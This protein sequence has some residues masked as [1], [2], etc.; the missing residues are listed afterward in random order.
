MST[1]KTKFITGRAG[2][3]KS[4]RLKKE[5]NSLDTESYVVLTPTHKSAKVL[6]D[7]GIDKEHIRTIHSYLGLIPT[8]NQEFR[9]DENI[10]KLE[11]RKNKN[12]ILYKY[13]FIDEFSMLSNEILQFFLHKIRT[14]LQSINMNVNVTIFG[15]SYQLPPVDG[16]KIIPINI[17][18]DVETL[19]IQYRADSKTIV[20]NF[21][22]FVKYLETN[23]ESLNLEIEYDEKFITKGDIK[24]FNPRTDKIVAFTNKKVKK[25]NDEVAGHLNLSKT[26]KKKDELVLNSLDVVFIKNGHDKDLITMFPTMI[27]KGVPAL[28]KEVS[29][30]FILDI[31]TYNIDLS[32]YKKCVV[33]YEGIYMN[34]FYNTNWYEDANMM[35]DEVENIQLSLIEHH[36]I[37]E[38]VVLK[39]WCKSNPKAKYVKERGKAWQRYLSHQNYVFNLQRP[40]ASTVHKSQ[41]SEYSTMFISIEDI[42]KAKFVSGK[43]MWAR[44]MYVSLSRAIKKIVII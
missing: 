5:V 29:N 23:D 21:E 26:Y 38:D 7:K 43:E 6:N 35:K 17:T 33:S 9:K 28:D 3:G 44:L 19:N 24:T 42:N 4:T 2:T 25:L 8:I 16:T 32:C 20:D 34:V 11:T 15:D 1:L 10:S 18:N 36:K 12:R 37:S 22:K 40:Y 31:E 39:N 30:E 27:K 41:G 14:E 13:I